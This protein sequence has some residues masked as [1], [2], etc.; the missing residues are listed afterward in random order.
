MEIQS[1]AILRNKKGKKIKYRINQRPSVI[2]KL[3]GNEQS[4]AK[5]KEHKKS[6]V[7]CKVEHVFAVVKNI[8]HY[9]STRYRDLKKQTAKQNTVFALANLYLA[10]RFYPSV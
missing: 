7:R 1:E 5:K 9:R 10:D 8:F 2:Q 3:P 4:K 6:S